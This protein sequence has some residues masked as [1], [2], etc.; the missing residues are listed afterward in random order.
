V[1]SVLGNHPARRRADHRAY[2]IVDFCAI[3]NVPAFPGLKWIGEIGGIS[4][5][6]TDERDQAI[7]RF[8]ILA[9]D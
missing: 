2:P 4:S 3:K 6:E 5:A 7:G 9:P 8:G 1:R